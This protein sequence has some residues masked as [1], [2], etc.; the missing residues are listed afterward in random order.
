MEW[1][2]PPFCLP[3]RPPALPWLDRPPM[4]ARREEGPRGR[5]TYNAYA[6]SL[7]LLFAGWEVRPCFCACCLCA[8]A[9]CGLQAAP[10]C[11]T[12]G[13]LLSCRSQQQATSL[14]RGWLPLR[15]A[16]AGGGAG[17][18]FGFVLWS[19]AVLVAGSAVCKLITQV[20]EQKGCVSAGGAAVE[21]SVQAPCSLRAMVR[22]GSGALSW[23]SQLC[24]VSATLLPRSLHMQPGRRHG[25]ADRAGRGRQ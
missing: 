20:V 21:C 10:A 15:V 19:V 2:R 3:D 9:M 14:A 12:D 24:L 25:P 6:A 13:S 17:G 23:P 22:V 11:P 16:A 1:D 8:A 7:F 18:G 4:H 5:D